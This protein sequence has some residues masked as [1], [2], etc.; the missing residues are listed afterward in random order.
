MERPFFTIGKILIDIHESKLILIV[1]DE[2]V[3]FDF[4]KAMN[5]PNEK[6]ECLRIN[7]LDQVVIKTFNSTSLGTPLELCLTQSNQLDMENEDIKKCW[8]YLETG[9]NLQNKVPMIKQEETLPNPSK[10][11][12]SPDLSKLELK[13]LPSHLKYAILGN[14]SSYP[15]IIYVIINNSLCIVDDEKLLR[16]LKEHNTVIGWSIID[17]KGISPSICMHK[18]LMEDAFKPIIQPQR[19]LNL[20]MQEVLYKEVLKLLDTG[21]INPISDSA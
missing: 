20:T 4:Y 21:I 16:I 5:R 15:V 17:I 19:R 12:T 7:A 11:C 1:R 14:Y 18:I 10:L 2:K 9:Q 3:T 8:K 6:D 13:P